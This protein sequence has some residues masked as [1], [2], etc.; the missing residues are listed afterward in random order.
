[1]NKE[2][3][4]GTKVFA[5]IKAEANVFGPIIWKLLGEIDGGKLKESFKNWLLAQKNVDDKDTDKV[6]W[7]KIIDALN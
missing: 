7:Q 2:V 1:M 3:E 6:C 5:G 4:D